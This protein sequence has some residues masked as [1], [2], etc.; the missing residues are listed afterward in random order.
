MTVTELPQ[1]IQTFLKT[2]FHKTTPFNPKLGLFP[3]VCSYSASQSVHLKKLCSE[4]DE[5]PPS[6]H[7]ADFTDLARLL[8]EKILLL[9]I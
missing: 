9:V 3:S 2:D 1:I 7:H 8:A 5:L 6:P 4:V